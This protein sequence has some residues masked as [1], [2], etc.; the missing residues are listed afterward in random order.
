MDRRIEFKSNPCGIKT[1]EQNSGTKLKN[2]TEEQSVL[3]AEVS[4][5]GG[6]GNSGLEVVGGVKK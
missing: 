1:Q 3:L 2:E 4:I 5:S 6:L